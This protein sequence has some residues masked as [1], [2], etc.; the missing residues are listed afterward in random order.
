MTALNYTEL[1][2]FVYV[3]HDDRLGYI[4]YGLYVQFA[5]TITLPLATVTSSPYPVRLCAGNVEWL[6]VVVHEQ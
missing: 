2:T 1:L 4:A 3:L 6:V 5:G